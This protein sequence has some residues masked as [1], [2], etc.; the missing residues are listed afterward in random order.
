MLV[1][2]VLCGLLSIV[3]SVWVIKAVIADN[4][5]GRR[6]QE[7]AEAIQKDVQVY[8]IRKYITI[9]VVGALIFAFIAMFLSIPAA[10]GFLV[11]AVLSGG[12]GSM[13]MVISVRTNTRTVQAAQQSIGASFDIA[14]KSAAVVGMLTVG[15]ALLGVAVYFAILTGIV[16]YDASD[17]VVSDALVAL[18][19]GASLISIV[20][21]LCGDI[22]TKAADR[23]RDLMGKVGAD[24]PQGDPRNP[25]TLADMMDDGAGLAAD[26]FESYAVTLVATMALGALYFAESAMVYSVMLYPLMIGAVCVLTSIAGLFFV[27]LGAAQS[28]RAALYRGFIA[29]AGLS[30]VALIPVTAMTVGLADEVVTA[31]GFRFTGWDLYLCGVVGIVSTG[32]IIGVSY[33]PV[34]QASRAATALPAVITLIGIIVAYL[35]AGLFGVAI[36]GTAM[37]ALAG[38]VGV[39]N[40]FGL[41]AD[42]AGSLAGIA[43]LPD[44]QRVTTDALGAAGN[45][46]KA[47]AKGYAI[48]LAGLGA[49]VL[50]VAYAEGVHLLSAQAQEGAIGH[51]GPVTLSNP[52]IVLG[53]LVGAL[54][55][56]MFGRLSMRAVGRAGAAVV[57]K[58]RPDASKPDNDDT[59]IDVLSRAVTKE[60]I[61]PFLLP[62]IAPV[63]VFFA[64]SAVAG[65]ASGFVALGAMVLGAVGSG[66]FM[67]AGGIAGPAMNPMM[68]ITAIVAFLLLA[69][70][71]Y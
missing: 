36:A 61:I 38:F 35:L 28:I 68:K 2:V 60:M 13:E 59:A 19:F 20:S 21:R 29:C 27:K 15:F 46:A 17:R 37:L 18:V 40:A 9:A 41:V 32:A 10:L 70:I 49:L 66:F 4:A 24:I 7:K 63:C 30:L 26:L 43:G 39:L 71:A 8:L 54:V 23:G 53:L 11:G 25:A 6:M 65:Y 22:F 12:A 50:F 67:V 34:A 5:G 33:H 14:L 51:G 52:Y 42:Q 62:V 1:L 69:V 3:Y 16:G 55:P 44:D 47:V 45:R 56:F 64:A 31:T 48:G 58:V 57:E